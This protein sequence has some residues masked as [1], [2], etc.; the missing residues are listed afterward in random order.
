MCMLYFYTRVIKRLESFPLKKKI[1]KKKVFSTIQ[2][3][4]ICKWLN[5]LSDYDLITVNIFTEIVI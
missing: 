3:Q 2:Q 5:V 1:K 4:Y